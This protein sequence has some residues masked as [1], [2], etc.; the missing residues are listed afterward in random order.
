MIFSIQTETINKLKLKKTLFSLLPVKDKTKSFSF[1]DCFN[2]PQEQNTKYSSVKYI[3][4]TN[5][6]KKKNP[7]RCLHTATSQVCFS[8]SS[9]SI[10]LH[11]LGI[12]RHHTS[13]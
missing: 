6:E 13:L 9:T 1:A 10:D 5:I 12:N 2:L 3:S 11:K 8:T 7:S 4:S